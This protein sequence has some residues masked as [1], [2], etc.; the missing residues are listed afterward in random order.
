LVVIIS[1]RKEP[2]IKRLLKDLKT[3]SS[4]LIYYSGRLGLNLRGTNMAL[5]D[6]VVK[7]FKD[8]GHDVIQDVIGK[9]VDTVVSNVAIIAINKVDRIM[10]ITYHIN[11]KPDETAFLTV[12]LIGIN[13][14]YKYVLNPSF[15]LNNDGEVLVGDDAEKFYQNRIEQGIINGFLEEQQKI[16]MLHH[17]KPAGT[18]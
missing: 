4:N 5:I 1:K 10:H 6:K 13:W 17:M 9:D 12:Q 14:R 7:V 15:I 11:L 18:A 3:F 16:H 2:L 8:R